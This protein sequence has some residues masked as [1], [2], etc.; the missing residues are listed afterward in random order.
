MVSVDILPAE[1]TH[2]R[3]SLAIRSRI[4]LGKQRYIP[5]SKKGNERRQVND[6][7]IPIF[8]LQF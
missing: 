2:A 1:C 8:S 5:R 6:Y 4:T 3:T 7:T